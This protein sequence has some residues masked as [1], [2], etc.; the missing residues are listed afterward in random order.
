MVE[1]L[2]KV[3]CFLAMEATGMN[4][5]RALCLQAVDCYCSLWGGNKVSQKNIVHCS[6][7]PPVL[8]KNL[9]ETKQKILIKLKEML[10]VAFCT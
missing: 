6:V 8:T 10:A 5:H 4:D 9:Y 7:K 3:L 1:L 2:D